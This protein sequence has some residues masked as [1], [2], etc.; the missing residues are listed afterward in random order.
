MMTS[1]PGPRLP[2]EADVAQAIRAGDVI[3]W[4]QP[5][6]DLRTDKIVGLE[7]LARRLYPDGRIEAA[8]AFIPIAERSDLII[9]LDIAIA[10]GALRDLR[11]WQRDRPAL[12]V[13][14]NMS[15]RHLD[16]IGWVT[17]IGELAAT[18]GV[19]PSTVQ[20]EITETA[21]PAQSVDGAA[22]IQLARS[23]GFS[24]WLDDFGSGWSGLSDLLHLSV[25][26]IKLDQSFAAALGTTVG[27]VIIRALTTAAHEL[28]LKVTMEGIETPEQAARA[29][30]LDCHYGQGFFWSRPV[31]ASGVDHL[32]T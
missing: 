10:G 26:G 5:I 27:D 11:R 30:D 20:L 31:P 24:L 12:R 4:Y 28:G 1:A 13:S 2:S 6:V 15:G 19:S 23:L 21:R 22:H 8:D 29:R 17:G 14:I 32:L 9:D 18:S 3:P 16:R 7:A 25:D